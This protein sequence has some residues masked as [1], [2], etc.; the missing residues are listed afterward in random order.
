MRIIVRLAFRVD[1]ETFLEVKKLLQHFDVEIDLFGREKFYEVVLK[2]FEN[3]EE[4]LEIMQWVLNDDLVRMV[5]TYGY[6]IADLVC[7]I[8]T[9]DNEKQLSVLKEILKNVAKYD[10]IVLDVE[11]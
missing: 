9:V 6:L 1:G 5:E 4:F 10:M 2:Y 3:T 7:F 11:K 8:F